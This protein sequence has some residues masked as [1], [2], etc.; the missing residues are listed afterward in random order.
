MNTLVDFKSKKLGS[1]EIRFKL[2]YH[3]DTKARGDRKAFFWCIASNSG[4][5]G[6]SPCCCGDNAA[7]ELVEEA[8]IS[9][10]ES[11]FFYRTLGLCTFR[12]N[13]PKSASAERH[14]SG[15]AGGAGIDKGLFGGIRV[16]N[17]I[18]IMLF[19]H[20]SRELKQEPVF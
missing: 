17:K 8:G 1:I 13:L 5:T 2:F 11:S 15:Q 9:E 6:Y 12:L 4:H 18:R 3:T 19:H 7:L 20:V 14:R 10:I 16:S